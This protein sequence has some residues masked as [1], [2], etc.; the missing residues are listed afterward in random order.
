MILC[1]SY[2]QAFRLL[3][4]AS[5]SD[6]FYLYEWHKEEFS[7]SKYRQHVVQPGCLPIG[8]EVHKITLQWISVKTVLPTFVSTRML[9]EDFSAMLEECFLLVLLTLKEDFSHKKTE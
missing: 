4:L 8:V 3:F 6:Q 7:Y 9:Q 5:N 2:I 1:F